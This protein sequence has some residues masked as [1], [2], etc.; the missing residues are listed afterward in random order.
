[1]IDPP[2]FKILGNLGGGRVGTYFLR[3][4]VPTL[5]ARYR[6]YN[7]PYPADEFYLGQIRLY[8]NPLADPTSHSSIGRIEDPNHPL[9]RPRFKR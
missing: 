1:M 2:Y 3:K 5:A 7:P 8:L 9:I 4:Y 6:P